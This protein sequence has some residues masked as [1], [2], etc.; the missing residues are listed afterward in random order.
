MKRAHGIS[1]LPHR[2]AH[3]TTTL[4]LTTQNKLEKPKKTQNQK[5]SHSTFQSHLSIGI[6]GR[7]SEG[8]PKDEG[9]LEKR[10]SPQLPSWLAVDRGRE[11]Q[12]NPTKLNCPGLAG[13]SSH[14][15]HLP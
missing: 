9:V 11:Q 2:T 10:G 6:P 7:H 14:P 4:T 13:A 8:N 3:K 1:I 12:G 15:S 5:H